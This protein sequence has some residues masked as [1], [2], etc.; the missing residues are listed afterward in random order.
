MHENNYFIRIFL[1][2][3]WIEKK[4][5]YFCIVENDKST[6]VPLC[7]GSTA[8]FGPVSLGSNPGGTTNLNAQI[9]QLVKLV[10]MLL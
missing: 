3:F 2:F 1:I 6:I 10:Y 7:N 8:G 5:F 9:A 4:K